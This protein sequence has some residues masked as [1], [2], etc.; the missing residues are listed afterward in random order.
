[1]SNKP[2][3]N[4]REDIITLVNEFYK[5]V[6]KDALLSPYFNDAA[7]IDWDHHLPIMYNFWETVLFAKPAY[8]GNPMAKHFNLNEIKKLTPE[9]FAH[10]LKLFHGTIEDLFQGAVAEKAKFSASTIAQTLE[11]RIVGKSR[12]T[13]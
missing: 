3:I 8:H 5:K 1:M 7:K 13:A 6:D 2:D 12:P 4:S 10:W 11:S 9:A